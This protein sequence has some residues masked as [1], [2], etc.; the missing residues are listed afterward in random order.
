MIDHT[1]VINFRIR[2]NTEEEKPKRRV[3]T[4]EQL[5]EISVRP[6]LCFRKY[7]KSLADNI[8]I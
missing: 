2:I 5:S 6:E 3:L 8:E 1:M 4:N 7:L